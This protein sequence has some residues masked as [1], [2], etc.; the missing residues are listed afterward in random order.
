MVVLVAAAFFDSAA[1]AAVLVF[2]A[3]LDAVAGTVAAGAFFSAAL[4][5]ATGL[6]ALLPAAFADA[7]F[8]VLSAVF[9]AGLEDF[10]AAVLVAALPEEAEAAFLGAM[11]FAPFFAEPAG[12]AADLDFAGAEAFAAFAAFALAATALPDFAAEA[13][14]FF[15]VV[16]ELDL[17]AEP[18]E[19]LLGTNQAFLGDTP[20]SGRGAVRVEG[21]TRVADG[22][23]ESERPG[24]STRQR[25]GRAERPSVRG[26]NGDAKGPGSLPHS[27]TGRSL[28]AENRK[29]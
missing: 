7:F 22:V 18:R 6:A 3:P 29:K 20:R 8:G 17:P 16:D 25:L 26:W 13:A 12:F 5:F 1:V 19:G 28:S 9:A 21:D 4:G 11:A 15:L 14:A 2:F 10:A 24:P 23:G 27:R